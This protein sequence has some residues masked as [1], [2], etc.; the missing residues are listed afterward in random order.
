MV[1]Y[2]FERTEESGK[3]PP[4]SH[5]FQDIK[6]YSNVRNIELAQDARDMLNLDDYLFSDFKGDSAEINLYIG[7]Y[8]SSAKAYA[9][10]SPLVCYPSQG[11]KIDENPIKGK[12]K[13]ADHVVNYEEIIT[14]LGGRK[15]LVLYWYQARL[16]TN[17]QVYRNKIDMG[18]NKFKYNDEQHGFVRVAVPFKGGNYDKAKAEVLDFIENFY[19]Q[20]VDY[21]EDKKVLQ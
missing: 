16:Q 11:W 10:H 5:Y 7:Y 13:V 8:Y 2:T 19:V 17:N 4:L 1:V 15:E 20:F 6:G 18:Y 3:K 14:S 9:A 21:V 12:L